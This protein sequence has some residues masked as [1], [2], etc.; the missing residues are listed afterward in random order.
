ML[1]F[2]FAHWIYGSIYRMLISTAI[3]KKQ[4]KELYLKNKY[5]NLK[6]EEKCPLNIDIGYLD[7]FNEKL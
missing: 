5:Q 3:K 7:A 2:S 4:I 6:Y 1:R